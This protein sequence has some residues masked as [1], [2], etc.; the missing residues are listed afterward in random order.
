MFS[1]HQDILCLIESIY[2]FFFLVKTNNLN[3]EKIITF[4]S[5]KCQYKSLGIFCKINNIHYLYESRKPYN[6]QGY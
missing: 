5:T 3:H 1:T 2:I 6:K 4:Y